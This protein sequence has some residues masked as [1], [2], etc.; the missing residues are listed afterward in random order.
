VVV[1]DVEP[2]AAPYR[3]ADGKVADFHA[4]R[5]TCI[6]NLVRAGV[7]PKEAQTLA[8]HSTITLTMDRYTHVGLHDIAGAG[9]SLPALPNASTAAA[10][11]FG[12]QPLRAT[13]TDGSGCTLVAQTTAPGCPPLSSTV[14]IEGGNGK[15]AALPQPLD[16]SPVVLH[17]PLD[18]AEGA[19]FEPARESPPCRFS[20]PMQS[21]AL[22]PLRVRGRLP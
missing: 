13:G 1:S 16:V 8:R 18:A 9:A 4:L 6:S 22:P 15:G 19:G 10:S 14:S 5:H 17:G 7:S 12:P 11:N 21:A 3:D 20:R 2:D